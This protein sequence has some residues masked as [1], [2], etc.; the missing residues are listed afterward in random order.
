MYIWSIL[1][2]HSA[3]RNSEGCNALLKHRKF[4]K[5]KQSRFVKQ[6]M[7]ISEW[8]RRWCFVIFNLSLSQIQEV[9]IG[10]LTV[11]ESIYLFVVK[12]YQKWSVS[13]HKML[14]SKVHEKCPYS[15]FFWPVSSRMRSISPYSVQM[16]KNMNQKNSEYGHFSRYVIYGS[17]M[18]E[19]SYS[20]SLAESGCIWLSDRGSIYSI[21]LF[22]MWSLRVIKLAHKQTF[23]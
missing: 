6:I 17:L 15:E 22:S 4:P 12:T 11:A 2:Q 21:L 10:S 9:V 1:N 3:K 7:D 16:R 13:H 23:F 14:L 19:Y 5:I 20:N 18:P 8:L